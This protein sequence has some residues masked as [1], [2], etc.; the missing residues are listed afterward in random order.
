[1]F[2]V[3]KTNPCSHHHFLKLN[4]SWILHLRIEKTK[5]SSL[6]LQTR[7]LLDKSKSK[8]YL[9]KIQMILRFLTR[10]HFSHLW[11]QDRDWR[12]KNP[13][14]IVVNNF[15]LWELFDDVNGY[16]SGVYGIRDKD[17]E[18]FKESGRVLDS[19]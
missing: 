7:C 15:F 19:D 16:Y 4:L 5:Q 11:S 17:T 14:N 9:S 6:G 1:M 12:Q 2:N 3:L 13:T 8:I 10:S 18:V